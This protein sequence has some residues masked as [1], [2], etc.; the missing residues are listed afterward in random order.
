MSNWD[1]GNPVPSDDLR[2][3]DDN[4]TT[5][6]QLLNGL[7]ASYP[8]RRGRDRKSWAQMEADSAALVA[9]NVAALAAL[10][11]DV[12]R[13]FFFNA[14]TPVGMGLYTLTS[15]VRGLGA[16]A[17]AAAFRAAAGAAASGA[18]SDITS[19]TGSAASLTN[20]RT[21]SATG[22]GTWSVSFNGTANVT[23]AFTLSTVSIAKGGTGATTQAAALTA[24]LGGVPLSI[25]QGGTGHGSVAFTNLPLN[26]GWT[27][28]ASR[29]AV[30]RKIIDSVELEVAL[31][32][33]TATD[34]TVIA[35]LPAGFRPPVQ[36]TI[37]VRSNPAAAP[38]SSVPVPSVVVNTDGTITCVNCTAA[39][40]INFICSFSTI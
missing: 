21:L 13:A 31:G 37:P 34:G 22:D 28:T 5:F 11:P 38:S 14:V 32:G 12:D 26:N 19:I 8:D 3:F 27:A 20:T 17:N 40:N 30:Y 39:G 18:N 2:D 24:L 10:T 7:A 36:F 33:G 23:A 4:A 29:R 15:F 35:T 9:P 16:S 25:A 1:T 6:D